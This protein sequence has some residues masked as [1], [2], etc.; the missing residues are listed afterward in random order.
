[1]NRGSLAL[2]MLKF[3]HIINILQVPSHSRPAMPDF[4]ILG[5][6]TDDPYTVHTNVHPCAR[7]TGSSNFISSLNLSPTYIPI[8]SSRIINALCKLSD[9]TA[10]TTLTTQDCEWED[11]C[12]IIP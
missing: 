2:L 5:S 7:V 1:M 4:E 12:D 8:P 9:T 11:T 6:L 10:T 3:N